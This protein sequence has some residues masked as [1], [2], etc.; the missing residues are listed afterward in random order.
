M[1]SINKKQV[2]EFVWLIII[3]SFIMAIILFIQLLI[4]I[5]DK[6]EEIDN[7]I[8]QKINQEKNLIEQ[9]ERVKTNLINNHKEEL[10]Q[11]QNQ[12]D[13]SYILD[14][15]PTLQ[16]VKNV[17]AKSTVHYLSYDHEEFNCYDFSNSLIKHFFNNKIYSCLV[18]IEFEDET[19]HAIVGIETSDRGI[20]YIEPQEK[21]KIIYSLNQ[22]DDYCS[23][24]NWDCKWEIQKV[25]TCFNAE[26]Y[27]IKKYT[28]KN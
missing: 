28:L 1:E 10:K 12:I 6:Q 11:L 14:Y 19:G 17:L 21:N 23:K 7:L 26:E 2:K 24:S 9:A 8:E 22:G 16:E 20:I 3:L 4:K 5:N 13:R 25:K 18:I 15:N 27:G